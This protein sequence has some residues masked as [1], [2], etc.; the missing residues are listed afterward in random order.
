MSGNLDAF[1]IEN[2]KAILR[3][4]IGDALTNVATQW[5]SFQKDELDKVATSLNPLSDTPSF[6]LAAAW[7]NTGIS[8][9]TT[10]FPESVVASGVSKLSVPLAIA[11]YAMD[12]FQASFKSEQERVEAM[13]RGDYVALQ[14][15]LVNA[16]FEV[17]DKLG[18]LAFGRE[19]KSLLFSVLQ[20]HTSDKQFNASVAYAH[21]A[22]VL[23]RSVIET[24]MGEIQRR[25]REGF[26]ALCEKIHQVYLGTYAPGT[27]FAGRSLTMVDPSRFE[28]YLNPWVGGGR[29]P[30]PQYDPIQ[31]KRASCGAEQH[32]IWS[33]G[34]DRDGGIT[35]D[36]RELRRVLTNI[37]NYDVQQVDAWGET[38][39]YAWP[40]AEKRSLHDLAETYKKGSGVGNLREAVAAADQLE[41]PRTKSMIGA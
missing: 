13:L 20:R 30:M 35:R 11:G 41:W 33:S 25:T 27:T 22:A 24:D 9:T 38:R 40:S 17:P 7:L 3:D 6:F 37:W 36:S 8:A 5:A 23:K 4:K 15:R 34:L 16:V 26:G 32:M 2:N 14:H 10:L 1:A 19:V 39:V 12:A 31:R 28:C 29:E 18:I 21:A